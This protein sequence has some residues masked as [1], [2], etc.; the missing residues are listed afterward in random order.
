MLSPLL[1]Q[2]I[3]PY[4]KLKAQKYPNNGSG[5]IRI[6]ITEDMP[7]NN[8]PQFEIEVTTPVGADYLSDKT[9]IHITI[10]P[11]HMTM[12]P[13]NKDSITKIEE[14]LMVSKFL[15]KMNGIQRGSEHIEHLTH[16]AVQQKVIRHKAPNNTPYAVFM[17]HYTADLL[18]ILATCDGKLPLQVLLDLGTCENISGGDKQELCTQLTSLRRYLPETPIIL[19]VVHNAGF[20]ITT[21]DIPRDLHFKIRSIPTLNKS[22]SHSNF[23]AKQR[24]EDNN[25]VM[26]IGELTSIT[27]NLYGKNF[28]A[29]DKQNL[30]KPFLHIV[31]G[32]LRQATK[33]QMLENSLADFKIRE[34]VFDHTINSDTQQS[35]SMPAVRFRP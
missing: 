2:P 3:Y 26:A 32:A 20:D 33:T 6:T 21:L 10:K 5:S 35:L 34:S 22:Q 23:L 14:L 16:I 17:S 13:D 25:L 29:E 7:K 24:I 12:K 30:N 11:I 4:G 28:R 19:T 31:D 9:E 8:S 1:S 15:H 27:R 18:A